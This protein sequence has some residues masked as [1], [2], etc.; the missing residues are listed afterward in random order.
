MSKSKL[1]LMSL[2]KMSDLRISQVKWVERHEMISDIIFSVSAEISSY[3]KYFNAY[4]YNKDKTF[5][6]P[7]GC[8][9]SKVEITMN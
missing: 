5:D 6:F 1:E 4:G 9:I 8:K 2:S 7:S 3:E